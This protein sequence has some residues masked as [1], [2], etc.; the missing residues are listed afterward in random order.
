MCFVLCVVFV[1]H[2]G[3]A[4]HKI[5]LNATV[6]FVL[7]EPFAAHEVVRFGVF[8]RC[9]DDLVDCN[10]SRKKNNNVTSTRL[11]IFFF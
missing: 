5:A 2:V 10:R 8:H 9:D 7:V 4:R 3:S 1:T 6:V 11:F